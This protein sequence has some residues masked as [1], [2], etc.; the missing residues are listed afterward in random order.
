MTKIIWSKPIETRYGNPAEFLQKV[1]EGY[2]VLFEPRKGEPKRV[3]IVNGEGIDVTQV[4]NPQMNR[5]AIRNVTK[6]YWLVTSSVDSSFMV[7]VLNKKVDAPKYF[8]PGR[9]IIHVREV[10]EDE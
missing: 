10:L 8:I 1:D 7:A 2:V 6:E 5:S 4:D 9:E 3:M